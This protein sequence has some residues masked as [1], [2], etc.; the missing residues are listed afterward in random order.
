MF[1]CFL[2]FNKYFIHLKS[3]QTDNEYTSAS[4]TF[5]DNNT[6][7]I[8]RVQ[9]SILSTIKCIRC[10]DDFSKSFYYQFIIGGYVTQW[11]SRNLINSI[12]KY[13]YSG[14]RPHCERDCCSIN[15][16]IYHTDQSIAWNSLLEPL[17]TQWLMIMVP[18]SV[19]NSMWFE[20]K[21]ICSWNKRRGKKQ[22]KSVLGDRDIWILI[23]FRF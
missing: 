12:S 16:F 13:V 2:S 3:H 19:S 21:W 7:Q 11:H 9:F 14:V 22:Y 20:W 6:F 5:D 10:L 15:I 23:Q 17:K 4:I 1:I 8:Q 18:R